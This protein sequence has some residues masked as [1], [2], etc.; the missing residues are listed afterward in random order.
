MFCS[1]SENK[2]VHYFE[3]NESPKDRANVQHK[4]LSLTNGWRLI[5]Q[6]RFFFILKQNI[7]LYMFLIFFRS[8]LET[9]YYFQYISWKRKVEIFQKNGDKRFINMFH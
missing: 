1:V 8:T 2:I 5:S 7:Q 9:D 3:C 6:I 4:Y